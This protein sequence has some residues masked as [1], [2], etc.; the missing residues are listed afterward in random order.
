MIEPLSL[1]LCKTL[2][3]ILPSTLLLAL[4]LTFTLVVLAELVFQIDHSIF[5]FVNEV[6]KIK[7]TKLQN[8]Y[9]FIISNMVSLDVWTNVVQ[10][11]NCQG[12]TL[13]WDVDAPLD[14]TFVFSYNSI[15]TQWPIYLSKTFSP[16]DY[17]VQSHSYP[18]DWHIYFL[19]QLNTHT[20]AHL[21]TKR[22][23]GIPLFKVVTD[24]F[25]NTFVSS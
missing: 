4:F 25:S 20:K 11:K 22:Y 12:I 6:S 17:P 2:Y 19:I 8:N 24:P 3:L 7:N 1:L 23:Q 5:L 18:I 10:N 13:F 9:Q 16:R 14:D 21:S 15:P